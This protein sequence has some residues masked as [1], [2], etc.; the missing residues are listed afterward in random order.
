MEKVTLGGDRLGAGKKNEIGLHNYERSTQ[1]L[2]NV[3]RTTMSAGTLVPFMGEISTP[4][5]DWEIDLDIDVKTMPT[6][7]PL[8]GSYKVQLDVFQVPIR[9]YQGALHMNL[10]GV[11]L[12]M[13]EIKLPQVELSA[14]KKEYFEVYGD[15]SQ[16][17]NSCIFA[18]Q[19]IR[20]LGFKTGVGSIS[21]D[22]NATKWL[23]YWDIYK[24]YY[25]NKQ[26][27]IGAVIHNNMNVFTNPIT[28]M[29]IVTD[30][31]SKIIPKKTVIGWS[32]VD[33]RNSTKII[34]EF[35]N[36]NIPNYDEI[37][38]STTIGTKRLTELFGN[39]Y[40]IED[41]NTI[42]GED[43]IGLFANRPNIEIMGY[44]YD[45]IG[46][47]DKEIPKVVTFNLEDIDS[48]KKKLLKLNDVGDIFKIDEDETLEPY[49]MILQKGNTN[50]YP[51]TSKQEGLGLKTYQSDLFNNWIST[52]WLDGTG[53]I[54]DI[55]AVD[56]SDGNF[57][58]NSLMLSRKIFDML[59]RIAVS[60][61]TYDDYLNAVYTHDRV[62]S[63]E[64]P[65]YCGGLIRELAFQEIVSNAE[66]E[67]QPLGTLA[68]KGVM[69]Q[70][71]KGGYIKIKVSEPSYVIGIVSITPRVDYS[72]GNKW[73]NNLKNIGELHKPALDEIGYQDLITDQM[74]WWDTDMTTGQ[75]VFKSAGKVPAWINYMTNV[76]TTYGNFADEANQMFM[77]LNR[78][79][80]KEFEET[81]KC[82]IKDLTTYIDPSKYNNIFAET[83]L[84]A[85][86]FWVQI[87]KDIKVRRKM[88][89]KVMPNL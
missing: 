86:N 33:L 52:E 24:Q 36:S 59:N 12:N 37:K 60:G 46:Y 31:V 22:F 61:G 11:G 9:L 29:E 3:I 16:V 87:S 44:I 26:E 62:R 67:G 34:I 18:Y 13:D 56:T 32:I 74:A 25:S 20:G 82:S 80:E 84:D 50:E 85:M 35:T 89:A 1:D 81:G 30:G 40:T 28:T 17:N 48:M 69:T 57:T 65:M 4:G 21:R 76:N 6:I 66:T 47:L 5:D 45:G 15:G 19:D 78:K 75:P 71:K 88:S 10:L 41:L 39:L 51:I 77:T 38:I 8:F 68:G 53:G 43:R 72:Q 7:G 14:R 42:V 83:R 55:T 2:S 70:K 27:G 63:V 73:D 23:A 58:L 49:S 79:Y 64:S 54:N